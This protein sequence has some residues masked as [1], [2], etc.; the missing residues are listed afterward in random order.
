MIIFLF[1]IKSFDT[2]KIQRKQ[3]I[4]EYKLYYS[5]NILLKACFASFKSEKITK[6]KFSYL[7]FH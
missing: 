6:M 2:F 5:R 1:L 7:V 4:R 3:N